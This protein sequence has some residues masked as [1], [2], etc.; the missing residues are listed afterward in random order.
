M[1]LNKYLSEYLIFIIRVLS[2]PKS[3]YFL[4]Y[5]PL[6]IINNSYFYFYELCLVIWYY[7]E[8]SIR[9]M[10]ICE[11]NFPLISESES[12]TSHNYQFNLTNVMN[13]IP[14]SSIQVGCWKQSLWANSLH[15]HTFFPNLACG[16]ILLAYSIFLVSYF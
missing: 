8:G 15:D 10:N 3:E 14:N 7:I 6:R 1:Q 12:Y 5:N 13:R 4:T 2:T 9:Y 11:R 16:S